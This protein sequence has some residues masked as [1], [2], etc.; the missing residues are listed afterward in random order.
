MIIIILYATYGGMNDAKAQQGR[1]RNWATVGMLY[2]WQFDKGG[3]GD[4]EEATNIGFRL[5][6]NGELNQVWGYRLHIDVPGL[7][8][9]EE[10]DRRG[11]GGADFLFFLNNAIV[12]DRTFGNVYFLAGLEMAYGVENT[13]AVTFGFDAGV[14]YYYWLDKNNGVYGEVD[15]SFFSVANGLSCTLSFGYQRRF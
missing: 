15:F 8:A 11:I 3:I 13:D 10:F 2:D 7:L 5:A 1:N 12:G 9:G 6:V 14:G 4:F